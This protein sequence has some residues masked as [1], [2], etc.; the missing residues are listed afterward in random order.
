M[1]TDNLS[2]LLKL[3]HSQRCTLLQEA[4][5]SDLRLMLGDKA[6][7]GDW[8]HSVFA[9]LAAVNGKLVTLCLLLCYSAALQV[10]CLCSVSCWAMVTLAHLSR[11][12]QH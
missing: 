12:L 11:A 10:T 2:S 4:A 8:S 7:H 5:A 6:R 1:R 9:R 3:L